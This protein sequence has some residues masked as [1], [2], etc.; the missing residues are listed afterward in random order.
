MKYDINLNYHE[1]EKQLRAAT[2]YTVDIL[3][4]DAKAFGI[5]VL[6]KLVKQHY[7]NSILIDD[8]TNSMTSIKFAKDSNP[9]NDLYSAV[10][11]NAKLEIYDS[12][13]EMLIDIF[14]VK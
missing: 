7:Q 5:E 10:L 1:V 2:R 12:D 3:D 4:L 14:D 13:C 11:K 9:D 6:M 8:I